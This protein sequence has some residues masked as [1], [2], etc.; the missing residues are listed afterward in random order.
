M[1]RPTDLGRLT[2]RAEVYIH[3]LEHELRMAQEDLALFAETS[4]GE[5]STT[6]R[7]S[8]THARLQVPNHAMLEVNQHMISGLC[9]SPFLKTW[10][11]HTPSGLTIRGHGPLVVRP[12][13]ANAIIV[14][15]R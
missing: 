4:E 9:A 14:F 15:P 2:Q 5:G 3:S 11:D 8:I 1:E 10:R 13:A 12:E 6:F 7:L